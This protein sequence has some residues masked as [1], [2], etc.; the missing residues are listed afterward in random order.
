MS[1]NVRLLESAGATAKYY[2]GGDYI[3]HEGA[4]SFYYYQII[5]GEIKL[6]NYNKDGKEFIQEIL[7]DGEG[8]GEALLFSEK[9]YPVNS[10][11]LTDCT[12]LRLCKNNFL[13]LL[14]L[15]PKVYMD[16]CKSLSDRIVHKYIMLQKISSQNPVERLQGIMDFLKSSQNEQTPFSFQIP[17]TR[18]QL[19]SLTGLCV[20]TAIRTIKMM[21]REKKLKIKNRKILY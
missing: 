13:N 11:A 15:Y 7:S 10:I 12:V 21:E 2:G 1:I 5:E 17:F 16:M 4:K 9:V 19:A 6:N 20:E 14:N 18:Q 3:F 8:F